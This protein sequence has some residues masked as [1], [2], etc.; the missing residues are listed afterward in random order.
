MALK[1]TTGRWL[2]ALILPLLSIPQVVLFAALIN[3]P[4]LR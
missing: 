2:S 1:S 3:Q 4:F